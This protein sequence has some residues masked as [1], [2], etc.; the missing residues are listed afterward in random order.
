MRKY[1][2][3]MHYKYMKNLWRAIT[4]S[5]AHGPRRGLRGSP[6]QKSKKRA[7]FVQQILVDV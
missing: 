4:N 2:K 5:P 6:Q 3:Y 7:A 1:Q